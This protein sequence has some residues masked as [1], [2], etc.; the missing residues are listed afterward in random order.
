MVIMIKIK[1]GITNYDNGFLLSYM[2][3]LVE[4]LCVVEEK[5]ELVLLASPPDVH[6]ITIFEIQPTGRPPLFFQTEHI[7]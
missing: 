1:T 4:I 3:S 5:I 7:C 2:C 6:A